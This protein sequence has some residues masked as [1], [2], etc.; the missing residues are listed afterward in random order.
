MLTVN[1]RWSYYVAT[2]SPEE[3]ELGLRCHDGALVAFGKRNFI[4]TGDVVECIFGTCSFWCNS[5]ELTV[6]QE[7]E[8]DDDGDRD[9]DQ[10]KKT[11]F[12]HG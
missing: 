10:P 9:A 7:V 5:D 4:L 11:T 6:I 12:H 2:L 1:D 8:D 3:N